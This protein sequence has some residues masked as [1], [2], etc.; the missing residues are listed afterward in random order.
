MT[1]SL[2]SEERISLNALVKCEGVHV[3][4]VW[5][6]C[7]HGCK[8]HRLESFNVGGR[9]FTTLLAYERWLAKLNGEW[10]PMRQTPKQRE[11]AIAAAERE[12]DALGI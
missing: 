1:D 6:W 9:K 8:G 10:L 12:L 2:F 5:R 7:L 4:T 3:C 11:Q